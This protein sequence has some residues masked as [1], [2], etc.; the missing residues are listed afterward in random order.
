MKKFTPSQHLSCRAIGDHNAIY[1]AEVI[2]RTNKTV[3][4][5]E[6]FNDKKRCKI[7]LNDVGEYIFPDGRYS[8]CPVF[9]A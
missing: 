6:Q 7:H 5:K 1:I 4:I 2:S 9:R 3:T 8:M